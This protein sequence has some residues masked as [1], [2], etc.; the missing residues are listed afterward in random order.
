M[1][2][3]IGKY[4]V[5]PGSLWHWTGGGTHTPKVRVVLFQPGYVLIEHVEKPKDSF[6]AH[7]REWVHTTVAANK[8]MP[9]R[10]AADDAAGIPY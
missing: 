10:T 8:L 5:A 3:Q 6:G 9:T 4:E 1:K 2:Q 7:P